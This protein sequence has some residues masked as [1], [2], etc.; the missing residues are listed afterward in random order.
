MGFLRGSQEMRVFTRADGPICYEVRLYRGPGSGLLLAQQ[1][2][3]SRIE[4]WWKSVPSHATEASHRRDLTRLSFQTA[5]AFAGD[6]EEIEDD[7]YRRFFVAF[8]FQAR[9]VVSDIDLVRY[10]TEFINGADTPL[11]AVF[12]QIGDSPCELCFVPAAPIPAVG[13]LL[14]GWTAN[15]SVEDVPYS[16]LRSASLESLFAVQRAAIRA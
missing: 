9:V 3:E 2:L 10:V 8:G 11:S 14:S 16:R 5:S 1:L 12:V 13:C 6:F 7:S 15:S 4:W